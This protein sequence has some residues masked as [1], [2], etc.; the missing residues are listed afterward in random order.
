MSSPSLLDALIQE[1]RAA[2]Q[3]EAE[4]IIRKAEEEAQRILLEAQERARRAREERERRLLEEARRIV[5]RE[6]A[7]RR[8]EIRRRIYSEEYNL[9][10]GELKRAIGEA[11]AALR[12]DAQAYR[13]YL[14][15]ALRAALRSLGEGIIV[16][17]CRGE[18]ELVEEV[19]RELTSSNPA[20]TAQITVGEEVNCSGGLLASRSDGRAYFNATFDA[21]A[22]EVFERLLPLAFQLIREG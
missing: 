11:L 20:G 16:H 12:G 14:R 1:I 9:V 15:E 6:I 13:R 10:A 22:A 3:E 4:A 17:P 2:A 7:P 5:E 19:A 8:L 18:R 21:K